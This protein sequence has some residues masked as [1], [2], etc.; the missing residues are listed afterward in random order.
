MGDGLRDDPRKSINWRTYRTGC[1]DYRVRWLEDSDTRR[2]EP[3][4]QVYCCLNT[5]PTTADEQ[6]K[7]LASPNGCW[8]LQRR[9][10][11]AGQHPPAKEQSASA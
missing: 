2:G 4:Y 10:T 7:C 3:L 9:Q 8:R 5:P 1:P 6:A 11:A